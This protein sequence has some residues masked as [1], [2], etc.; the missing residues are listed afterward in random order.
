MKK[1]ILFVV[2]EKKV[3]GVSVLLADIINLL[4]QDKYNIDIKYAKI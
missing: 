2:D 4:N 1:N 3:G